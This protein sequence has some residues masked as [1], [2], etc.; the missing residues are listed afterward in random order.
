[1]FLFTIGGQVMPWLFSGSGGRSPGSEPPPKE[2]EA[3][4]N[5]PFSRHLTQQCRDN[6]HLQSNKNIK[7]FFHLRSLLSLFFHF[8]RFPGPEGAER[9]F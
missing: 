9:K 3:Q 7:I 5:L 6:F 1:M 4:Q 8:Q 2:D